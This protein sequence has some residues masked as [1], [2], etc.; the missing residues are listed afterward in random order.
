MKTHIKARIARL[1]AQRSNRIADK[2]DSKQFQF[3]MAVMSVVAFHAGELTFGDSFASALARGLSITSLE[4][5]NALKSNNCDRLN[6]WALVLEKL[7]DLSVLRG[8]LP[9]IEDR[10]LI[11]RESQ[12]NDD[13]ADSLE[14]LD[15]LYDEIPNDLKERHRLLPHLVNY[16]VCN[17]L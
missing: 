5:K 3:K 1:E 13:R 14:M 8:G 4:L 15:Q 12:E 10:S 9:I 16:F 11:F 17:G 2:N 6:V 7:N